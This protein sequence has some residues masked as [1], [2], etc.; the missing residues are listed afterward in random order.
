M[1][2]LVQLI[3]G[4]IFTGMLSAQETYFFSAAKVGS[5]ARMIRLGGVEGMS[6]KSDSVFENPAA[7]YRINRFSSSFFR[8]QFMD[9]VTFE[10][11]SVAMR[12]PFGV[13]GLGFMNLGVDEI[14]KT[15]EKQLH[16][17]R[18]QYVVDY[19]FN[20]QNSLLKAVYQFSRSEL[21]HFGVSGSYYFS[22][23]DTVKADGFNVDFGGILNFDSFNVSVLMRNAMYSNGVTFT[24][25]EVGDNSSDGQVEKLPFETVYSVQ[26]LLRNF[27]VY[28]QLKTVGKERDV[29]K[30]AAIEFNPR[31]LPSVYVSG[32][33][34]QF[35]LAHYEEGEFSVETKQSAVFG[36]TLDLTGLTF[37]YAYERS[38]HIEYEHK[39][40][41]SAGYSF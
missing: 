9:E 33:L 18:T 10:N 13:L 34:K 23:F 1:K 40:Y 16:H 31:F 3:I 26:Y 29:Y 7:L 2:I 21:L 14:P 30:S 15:R 36:V 5:S 35:P 22:K 27:V 19:Y 4:L 37:D 20:Y 12:F 25:T 28:G 38:D 24:D 17:D 39:H 41:F 11:G 8:T 6:S 32:S